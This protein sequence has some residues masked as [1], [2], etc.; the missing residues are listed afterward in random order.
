MCVHCT[1][2][3]GRQ[4]LRVRWRG[5]GGSPLCPRHCTRRPRTLGKRVATQSDSPRR[6]Q[7]CV[8]LAVRGLGWDMTSMSNRMCHRVI[9]P[10]RSH[11]RAPRVSRLH[12]ASRTKACTTA[13]NHTSTT[14]TLAFVQHVVRLTHSRGR[15]IH[16]V[17]LPYTLFVHGGRHADPHREPRRSVATTWASPYRRESGPP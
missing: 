11:T 10:R 1:S 12:H 8:Q 16:T 17:E 7:C 3:C 9:A 14:T 15:S 6:M 4:W 2:W 13:R 5:P